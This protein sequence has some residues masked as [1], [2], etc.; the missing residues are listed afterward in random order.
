M[1]QAENKDEGRGRRQRAVFA[2]TDDQ[3]DNELAGEDDSDGDEESMLGEV[4]SPIT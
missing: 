3:L 2:K 4:N 1:A